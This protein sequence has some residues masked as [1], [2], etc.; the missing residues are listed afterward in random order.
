MKRKKLVI[1]LDGLGYSMLSKENT[2]FLYSFARKNSLAKLKT[3]LAFTGIEFSFFSGK[4]PE[5]HDVWLEFVY[6][7]DTS[8][9]GWQK[10]FWFLGGGILSKMTAL[11]MYL[12][13]SN[14]LTKLYNIPFDR[15]E[16][17]DVATRKNIWDLEMFRD[18]KY[19]CLKWPF[20][21]KNGK[22]GLVLKHQS[23]KE[24]CETLIRNIDGETEIYAVQLLELDKAMHNYGFGREVGG[25]LKEMDSLARETVTSF[26]KKV[27]E[28]DII[29][30]SDHGFVPVEK[31]VNLQSML[32]ERDDYI[33]FYGG[34]TASFWFKSKEAKTLVLKKLSEVEFGK[35]INSKERERYHIPSS[36]KH[37]EIIFM[38]KPGCMIFPNYYQRYENEK[39]KAMHGYPPD[40]CD[41][42]GMLITNIKLK[43]DIIEMPEVLAILKNDHGDD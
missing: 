7:P 14:F 19:L 3:L 43:K 30:W 24:R 1:C 36:K 2:P 23:D 4:F 13:G 34:T 41:A 17:F 26:M 42:D 5:E 16:F 10:H 38:V 18:R 31:H 40:K 27:P 20:L 6:S 11:R 33:A 15:L 22:K 29:L 21:V 39:F 35:I 9:F 37:G 12:G 32:P 28:L 25:T 8:P